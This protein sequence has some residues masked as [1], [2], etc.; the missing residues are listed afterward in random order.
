MLG[1]L[2][3]A[4]LQ[5]RQVRSASARQGPEPQSRSVRWTRDPE[6]RQQVLKSALENLADP[7][8]LGRSPLTLLPAL[9]KT[10]ASGA[11]LRERLVEVISELAAS[12]TPR[13]GEAGR[14]LLDYYVKRVGS[15]EVV[16][17]R[18]CL[19]RPTFYRRLQRGFE[20]VAERLDAVD[21]FT[22]RPHEAIA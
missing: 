16:M 12:R 22:T 11:V 17:E 21:E 8:A 4:Q 18:L 5:S 3:G 9:S 7:V 1:W 6:I 2:L 20:L 13:D 10:D 14:L 19:S 15:H